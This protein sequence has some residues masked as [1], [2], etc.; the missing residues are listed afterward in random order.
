MIPEQSPTA[1]LTVA[2]ASA[3]LRVH[4]NTTYSLIQ[5]GELAARRVG[6]QYRIPIAAIDEF[7]RDAAA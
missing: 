1:Y 7:D 4:P 6:R 3:R 5:R 2:E